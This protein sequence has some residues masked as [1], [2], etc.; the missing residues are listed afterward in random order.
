MR[1]IISCILFL[2]IVGCSSKAIDMAPEPTVQ[3]HDLRDIEG[4]GVIKARDECDETPA[5]SAINNTGCGTKTL[6]KIWRELLLILKRIL[7]LLIINIYQ[8]SK[9]YLIS[10]KSILTQLW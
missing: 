2:F 5:G 6:H 1:V 7:M 4:D 9:T 3:K 8:K 10:W